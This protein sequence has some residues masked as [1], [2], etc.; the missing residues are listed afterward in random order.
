[1]KHVRQLLSFLMA[2]LCL[3]LL[4]AASFAEQN[5]GGTPATADTVSPGEA[6]SA[7]DPAETEGIAAEDTGIIDAEELNRWMEDFAAQNNHAQAGRIFS[8][9]FWYSATGDSWYWNADEWMYSASMYKV[10][11]AML[12]AEKEAAGELT[13]ESI[14]N[15]TTLEYNESTSLIWSNNDSGHNMV[16]Y[17]GGT[18]GDKCS[19]M[20][21]KYADLP[22]DYYSD[23]FKEY[24]YYSARF[25]TQVMRTLYLGGDEAFPRLIGYL[26]QAQPEEYFNR[27]AAV[28]QQYE[29]AQK[30]GAYTEPNG[31]SNNHC[32]AIIYTPSPIVVTVMTRNVPDYQD[33]IAAVGAHLAEYALTLDRR[34]DD[35]RKAEAEREAA[36][37]A[38]AEELRAQQ[39][40]AATEPSASTDGSNSGLNQPSD[41]SSQ[42]A[43]DGASNPGTPAIKPVG[44]LHGVPRWLLVLIVIVLAVLAVCIALLLLRKKTERENRETDELSAW[45]EEEESQAKEKSRLPDRYRQPKTDRTPEMPEEPAE[46][47]TAVNQKTAEDEDSREKAPAEEFAAPEKPIPASKDPAFRVTVGKVSDKSTRK[48]E[49]PKSGGSYKPK[50]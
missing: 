29:V 1:M 20:A 41:G 34:L 23:N 50:H 8:V 49:R 13:A 35:W 30:F 31:N 26:K 47:E 19:T 14:L 12:L 3:C 25:M 15:G 33:Q 5:P 48:N 11:C 18:L 22:E 39:E 21:E 37:A 38:R 10:P 46:T 7:G 42:S 24:S 17:L 2:L 16:Y 4:P 40:A 27:D 9:G 43:S 6:E 28:R 32:T 44:A 45:A 36:E